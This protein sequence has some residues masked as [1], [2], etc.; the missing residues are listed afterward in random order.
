[1]NILI[2]VIDSANLPAAVRYAI[3]EFRVAEPL[4]VHLLHVRP[5]RNADSTLQPAREL[6]EKFHVPYSVHL[7][8]GDK[9][10][11]I[12]GEARRLNVDRIVLGIARQWSA[13][14]LAEDSVIRKVMDGAPVPVSLIE[15]RSVSPLERYAFPAAAAGIAAL[16][17]AAE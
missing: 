2:P 4:E 5:F 8:T 16:L 12:I 15:G 6:L 13:T 10:R 9:A 7:E 14:R 11:T 1:M 3:R 17:L